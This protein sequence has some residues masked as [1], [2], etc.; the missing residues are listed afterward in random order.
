MLI[1]VRG[2]Q[3]VLDH[4]ATFPIL[5]R[6]YISLSLCRRVRLGES[7]M[8]IIISIEL[9]LII[10]MGL[11]FHCPFSPLFVSVFLS[12]FHSRPFFVFIVFDL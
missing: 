2:I 8:T 11:L 4:L 6:F 12:V 3:F 9:T 7:M 5:P 10:Q 1:L